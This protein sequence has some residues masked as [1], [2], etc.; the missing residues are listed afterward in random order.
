MLIAGAGE[1]GA[2]LTEDLAR[3]RQWRVV[4]N[5]M[6]LPEAEENLAHFRQRFSDKEVIPVSAKEQEGIDSLKSALDRWLD[7]GRPA[8]LSATIRS[9]AA[10][11]STVCPDRA[12]CSAT[13]RSADGDWAATDRRIAVARG[14]SI[15]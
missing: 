13:S 8:G 10:S 6:D 1:A 14:M 2:R 11:A 15:R 7:E 12:S 4:A 9:K 3:S 5:K